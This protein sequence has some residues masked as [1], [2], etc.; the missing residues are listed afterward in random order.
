[1]GRKSGDLILD[2]PKVSNPHAKF[3]FE[4]DAFEIWDFGSKNGTFVNGERIRS[5]TKLK[6]NDEVKI[7]D[8]TFVLKVLDSTAG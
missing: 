7:G 4:N 2:D 8:I 1:M 6:E 5:A 3:K